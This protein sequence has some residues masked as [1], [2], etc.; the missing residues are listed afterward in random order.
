MSQYKDGYYVLNKTKNIKEPYHWVLKAPNHEIILTSENYVSKHG[1]L[2]GM[3]SVR[4]NCED[5]SNYQREIAKDNSPYF[6]LRAKN[7]EVIGTSEMYS[8]EKARETGITA[9]KNYGTT[10]VLIDESKSD[11]GGDIKLGMDSNSTDATN[12]EPTITQRPEK[13]QQAGRYA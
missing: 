6:N 9:V 11:D 3:D 1:A 7:Y 5:D 4:N 10:I 13:S 2:N 12:E 8:S